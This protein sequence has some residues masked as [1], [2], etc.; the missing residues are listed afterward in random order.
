M[1]AA[2]LACLALSTAFCLLPVTPAL[3]SYVE[4]T[5]IHVPHTTVEEALQFRCGGAGRKF[6]L[7]SRAGM[8]PAAFVDLWAVESTVMSLDV[9]FTAPGRL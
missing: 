9:S 8:Q 4:Q 2:V 1:F 7:G 3:C 5:D 6:I